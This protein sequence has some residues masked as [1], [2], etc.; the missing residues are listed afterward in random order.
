MAGRA[1]AEATVQRSIRPQAV[2]LGL[3]AGL[4]G[5]GAWVIVGQLASRQ[6]VVGGGDHRVLRALGMSRGQLMAVGLVEVAV[7]AAAGGTLAVA[8]A[9]A[10]SP[11]MPIGPAR[12][13]EPH[14]GVEFN[15]AVL[16]IG[17]LAIVV[18]MVARVAW[19]AW[20]LA[21][22]VGA[23]PSAG[24]EAGVA[25][26]STVAQG[27]SRV[28]LPSSATVGLRMGS[29]PAGGPPCRFA[30]PSAQC[31]PVV[32]PTCQEMFSGAGVQRPA[33]LQ[34]VA[35][36]DRLLRLHPKGLRMSGRLN[37]RHPRRLF[38]ALIAVSVATAACGGGAGSH[39]SG[40]PQPTRFAFD[41]A[42]FVDPTTS[43]N[44]FDPL[45]PGTQWVRGG[46]TEVGSRKVPHQVISTMTDVVRTIDGVK[47][48]AMLDQ[49]TDSGE[50]SQVGFD[51]FAL[52]KDGNVWLVGGYT[53]NYQ[54]G[55]F[56]NA[57]DAW[58]GKASGGSPGVLLPGHVDMSTPRW[59]IASTDKKSRGSVA[60]PAAVGVSRCVKFKCFDGVLMVREGEY[61]AIDNE[62]KYYAPGVG[63]IDNVPHGASVHQDTFQLLNVV[64]LTP[65]GLAEISQI[66][67][68]REK[69]ARQTAPDVYGSLPPAERLK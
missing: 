59:F 18:L 6:V 48:V 64:E 33:R 21:A 31:L 47:A 58:L 65:A 26:V 46:T 24:D 40:G 10:A 37:G 61:G 13:A 54:G 62:L 23:A 1:A 25:R 36:S 69:H 32:Q 27:A 11:L 67:L 34:R 39:R 35:C 52:D 5:I 20:G 29:R 7:A 42:N 53:E 30:A 19:P 51:W 14:V 68:D 57:D 45:R 12:L 55:Q 9:I 28:G 50:V 43:T 60:E 4:A 66:V 38:G 15:A 56:T 63:I 22:F 17:W 49:S 2:A 16:T 8:I 44:P 41:P 3:F